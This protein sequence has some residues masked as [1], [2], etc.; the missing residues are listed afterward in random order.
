MECLKRAGSAG[1]TL[2]SAEQ[3][4]GML[5]FSPSAVTHV[6]CPLCQSLL[7]LGNP[8]VN[9]EHLKCLEL[10]SQSIIHLTVH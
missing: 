9:C 5:L 4:A 3:L 8:L 6:L 10:R 1:Y 7:H 2:R